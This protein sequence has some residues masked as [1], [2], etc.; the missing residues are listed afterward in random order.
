ME[1][2]LVS[3]A[4]ALGP[5]TACTP[6]ILRLN[7]GVVTFFSAK[8]E[9]FSTP[10]T[11][12]KN[13]KWPWLQMGYGV[14]LEVNGKKYKFTFLQPARET[15]L[16]PSM[17]TDFGRVANGASSINSLIHMKDHKPVAKA[18]REVLRG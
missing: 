12:I 4:W 13:V 17:M 2:E 10:V 9:E 11:A 8:G 5:F 18:W 1:K 3:N 16:D 14:H 6:G 7:E 15:M